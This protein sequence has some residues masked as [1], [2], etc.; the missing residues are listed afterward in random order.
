MV[1]VL[2]LLRLNA[3]A[4]AARAAKALTEDG[5]AAHLAAL[6]DGLARFDKERLKDF[7]SRILTGITLNPGG[8]SLA[9]HYSIQIGRQGGGI[10]WRPHGDSNPGYR[11]ERAM[12]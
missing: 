12:S 2:T 11:R 7:L 4:Q 10:S 1:R 8:D 5:V 6:G 3:E 9:L